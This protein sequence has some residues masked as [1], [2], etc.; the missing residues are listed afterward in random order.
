M[1]H[2][3]SVV[4]AIPSAIAIQFLESLIYSLD[5]TLCFDG[6][7]VWSAEAYASI[8]DYTCLPSLAE[9][10][11]ELMTDLPRVSGTYNLAGLA[12]VRGEVRLKSLGHS[13]SATKLLSAVS[14]E[15]LLVPTE[16]I[17]LESLLKTVPQHA[18]NS[19]NNGEINIRRM[20]APKISGWQDIK[21]WD[22]SV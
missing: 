20:E 17:D 21:M 7:R 3:P 16:A 5:V 11:A 19:V 1:D 22:G 6:K 4:S 12:K 9:G 14:V 13:K 15:A 2:R 10:L 18:T 8:K